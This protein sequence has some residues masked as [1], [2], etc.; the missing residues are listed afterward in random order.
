MTWYHIVL[1][2]LLC[3]R[4]HCLA[5]PKT[6]RTHQIRVHLQHAGHPIA[7]DWQY[8][9]RLGSGSG[10][11][12]STAEGVPAA[13][14]TEA[15]NGGAPALPSTS[16]LAVEQPAERAGSCAADSAGPDLAAGAA[17]SNGG[18]AQQPVSPPATAGGPGPAAPAPAAVCAEVRPPRQ[19]ALSEADELKRVAA[20]FLVA[21]GDR[22]ELCMHC[23]SLIPCGEWR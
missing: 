6:G 20:E 11:G 17:S 19:F 22:D 16:T 15:A 5:R 14:A 1:S 9:S 13:A 8:G 4:A 3:A 12:R 2:V 18:A 7:N 10:E 23:P 21:P